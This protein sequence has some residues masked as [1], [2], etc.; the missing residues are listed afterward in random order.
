MLKYLILLITIP[1]IIYA[2]ETDVLFRVD[3]SIQIKRGN[4]HPASDQVKIAGSFNEWNNGI[5]ILTDENKDSLYEISLRFSAGDTIL[6]KFIE[7]TNGWEH[8][9]NR[10]YI[11]PDQ[12]SVYSA[13]F[14][15][16]TLMPV[17][18]VVNFTVNMEYEI[19]M[20]HFI[21]GRDTVILG[22]S[23]NEWSHNK[24]MQ[25]SKGD[26][27]Y[28]ERVDTVYA[29]NNDFFSFKY[30]YKS[31]GSL[32][33]EWDP[34]RIH[35]FTMDDVNGFSTYVDRIF[36]DLSPDVMTNNDLIVTFHVHMD[37]A[38]NSITG[39]EFSTIKNVFITGNIPPLQI[40][41]E[42]W[43]DSEI[44]KV[45]FLNDEGI[46]GDE[47]KGDNIWSIDILFKKY[48]PL[49][50][51]YKFGANWGIQENGG[52]NENEGKKGYYHYMYF[53]PWAVGQTAHSFFG[54]NKTSD[55]NDNY[56][57]EISF[58][59]NQ[60]YPNPFN[61]STTISF[62]VAEAGR[63]TLKVYDILGRE[64]AEM[65]NEDKYPG[66]YS[67]TYDASAL[68]SGTYIYHLKSG[69][70]TYSRKMLLLK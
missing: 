26:P 17:N 14:N 25:M 54:D 20:E 28:Y 60:N 44:E 56:F 49:Y 21:P 38:V 55:I 48:S 62:S 61:P 51:I 57:S 63:V 11:V 47:F 67:I 40:P 30:G 1:S 27:N 41:V 37:N 31:Q 52:G 18:V 3:M 6:F 59:L 39:T 7:G 69:G 34:D 65:F 4:F 16:N 8:I 32:V 50:L 13:H 46:N 10:E 66:T 64:V 9:Y 19:A 53:L 33:W 24:I 68:P 43:P 15:N 58:K 22:T 42:G 2:I 70:R 12:N 23:Y 45:I 5:S 35:T 29:G 36:N